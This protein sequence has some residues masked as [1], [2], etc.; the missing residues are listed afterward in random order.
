MSLVRRLC[1]MVFT[2]GCL[3]L[4]T[5]VNAYNRPE[6]EAWP[7]EKVWHDELG[8]RL[9]ANAAL[10]KVGIQTNA[11]A[12][13][14]EGTC[15][16]LGTDPYQLSN[17][18]ICLQDPK[19]AYQFCD[20]QSHRPN[21][22]AYILTAKTYQDIR[23]GFV[24]ANRY[25]IPVSVKAT[26]HSLHGGSTSKDSLLIWMHRFRKDGVVRNVTDSCGNTYTAIGV[27]GGE[28][29]DDVLEAVKDEYHMVTGNCRTVGAAGGWL[30]GHGLSF[31]SRKYGLGIDQVVRMRVVLP[32]GT[33]VVADECT[34]TDL[35]WALRGGGG[36]TFGI[37]TLVQYK[38]Y[39]A[40]PIT[41]LKFKFDVPT[42]LSYEREDLIR[43][44]LQY[45]VSVSPSLEERWSG[46]FS[47]GEMFLSFTGTQ[48]DA[49]ESF[50]TEFMQWYWKVFYPSA[51]ETE[52]LHT[53]APTMWETPS[54]YQ[55][56]GGEEAYREPLKTIQTGGDYHDEASIGARLVPLDIALTKPNLLVDLLVD[57]T[58]RGTLTG[59]NYFLGGNINKIS[60]NATAVH[61]AMRKAIYHIGVRDFT[62]ESYKLV[63]DFLPNNITGASFNHHYVLEPDWRTA[64]WGPNFKRLAELKKEYDP[65][66]LLNCWHC[67]GYQG[68]DPENP[69][70][71][72]P[73]CPS[74]M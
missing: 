21:W 26:G 40:T 11:S 66:H 17:T 22:P 31:T 46:S 54:W 5:Q 7:S 12:A 50:G 47:G 15:F 10:T 55:Y 2:W 65:D 52:G 59:V 51:R 69:P 67:V 39:S 18:S 45:W 63:R 70:Y 6:C 36:G 60:A 73:E 13:F 3:L 74:P 48:S 28:Q 68:A 62:G 64:L 1:R 35:F 32:N 57:L 37:V 16:P 25:D 23:A 49:M 34:N 53:D 14:Y 24:F 33:R 30:Q 71:I 29:W 61:P 38:V 56:K 27:G 4:L 9:S 20:P 8:Q 72:E 42:V 58:K 44:W 43:L 41:A 19:C